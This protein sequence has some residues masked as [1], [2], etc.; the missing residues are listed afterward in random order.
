MQPNSIGFK[1]IYSA[2]PLSGDGSHVLKELSLR[3][4][5][6]MVGELLSKL[7]VTFKVGSYYQS[8]E[9]VSKLG[10]SLKV[11]S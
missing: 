11:G 5:V 8:W 2:I 7:G 4:V 3:G 1:N 9:L 6:L 10:V